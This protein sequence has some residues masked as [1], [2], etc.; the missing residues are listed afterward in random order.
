YGKQCSEPERCIN[1]SLR[2]ASVAVLGPGLMQL[3]EYSQSIPTLLRIDVIC[4]V[5]INAGCSF[6]IY[7]MKESLRL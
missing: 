4:P 6:I 3:Y 7:S 5:Q 1:Q 2:C